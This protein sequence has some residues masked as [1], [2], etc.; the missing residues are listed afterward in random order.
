MD[1]PSEGNILGYSDS[2]GALDAS[3]KYCTERRSFLFMTPYKTKKQKFEI[4]I[5]KQGYVAERRQFDT[6]QVSNGID[7]G[8][9]R[10]NRNSK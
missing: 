2:A 9:I 5:V 4:Q 1:A 10:L 7:M 8:E 6:A 3:A